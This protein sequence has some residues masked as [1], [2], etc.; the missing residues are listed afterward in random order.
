[1]RRKAAFM[2]MCP[3]QCVSGGRFTGCTPGF[4]NAHWHVESRV[5][6]AV[7]AR[8]NH[9]RGH[10][11]TLNVA[12]K[13]Y[14]PAIVVA[15]TK[16]STWRVYWS[17]LMK[18]NTQLFRPY[19]IP[20]FPNRVRNRGADRSPLGAQLGVQ[21]DRESPTSDGDNFQGITLSSEL[22]CLGH[23]LFE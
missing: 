18:R 1:M 11:S 22:L 13:A 12:T 15:Q 6:P 20:G 2:A 9:R 21:I 16:R 19:N 10:L 7:F 4:S 23:K 17:A 8:H 5:T 3:H 14:R